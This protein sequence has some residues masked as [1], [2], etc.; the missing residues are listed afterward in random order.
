MK[1]ILALLVLAILASCAAPTVRPLL[2]L[3]HDGTF[4]SANDSFKERW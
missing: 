4:A 3:R 1:P 2:F